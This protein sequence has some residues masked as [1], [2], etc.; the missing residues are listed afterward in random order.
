ME[1]IVL[2]FG[3]FNPVT[4]AHIRM[5]ILAKEKV[6]GATVIYVPSK[7]RFLRG[8]KG[9]D[10]ASVMTAETRLKLMR[11]ALKPLGFIVDD[12][13]ISTDISGKT[14]DTIA[15]LRKKYSPENVYICMG[16]DKLREIHTWYKGAELI[17]E[18]KWLIIKRDGHS[19]LDEA[20]GEIL[21]HIENFTEI[22]NDSFETVSASEIREAYKE[23]RLERIKGDIPENV[24]GFLSQNGEVYK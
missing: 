21:A 10:E 1:S 11:D 3:T 22:E 8:W 5:G 24:Y 14:Y 2:I 6:P 17:S 4:N 23:G 20:S 9:L 15:A 19:V 16:T 18:N 13:E 12:I 7:D